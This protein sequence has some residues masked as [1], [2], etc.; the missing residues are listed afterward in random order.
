MISPMGPAIKTSA[1]LTGR[2]RLTEPGVP[3][4]P[5]YRW[6]ARPESART[7]RPPEPRSRRGPGCAEAC[8]GDV[9]AGPAVGVGTGNSKGR[10]L[11]SEHVCKWG[12]STMFRGQANVHTKPARDPP[13]SVQDS[14]KHRGEV[15]SPWSRRIVNSVMAFFWFL[16]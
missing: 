15:L 6:A 11:E 14:G 12:L 5:P 4:E 16:S 3:R 1:G 8:T 10:H 7:H 13:V 2:G 9:T